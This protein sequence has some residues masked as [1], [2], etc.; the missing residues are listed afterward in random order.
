LPP[1]VRCAHAA[2]ILGVS[3][4]HLFRR[5][6][7]ETL[8]STRVGAG[9]QLT[10][11]SCTRFRCLSLVRATVFKETVPTKHSRNVTGQRLARRSSR[12]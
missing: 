10:K 5:R 8:R 11:V 6:R 9:L 3:L 4:S 2:K 1:R 7:D 12:V